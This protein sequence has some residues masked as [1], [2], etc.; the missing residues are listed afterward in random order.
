MRVQGLRVQG[1][2]VKVPPRVSKVVPA[3][4]AVAAAPRPI[5]VT[6]R[7]V[8]PR[9]SGPAAYT[10]AETKG[11]ASRPG[12]ET[13]ALNSPSDPVTLTPPPRGAAARH[14][15][16]PPPRPAAC[17]RTDAQA[18]ID[19]SMACFCESCSQ[20]PIACPFYSS[21]ASPAPLSFRAI[22]DLA[23]QKDDLSRAAF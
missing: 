22:K 18:R 2:R 14:L 9:L 8:T 13:A 23:P 21:R 6:P 11:L 15:A 19:L 5:P 10:T 17:R 4:A 12:S 3:P 1:M 7:V 20:H 16:A